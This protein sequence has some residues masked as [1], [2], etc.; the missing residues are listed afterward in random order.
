M[1]S[2]LIADFLS[3]VFHN[4]HKEKFSASLQNYV[5]CLILNLENISLNDCICYSVVFDCPLQNIIC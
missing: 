5:V 1:S 3:N 2:I 4:L